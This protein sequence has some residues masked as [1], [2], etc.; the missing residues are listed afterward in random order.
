MLT[1][2]AY[3]MCVE[4]F[5]TPDLGCSV[6]AGDNHKHAY[7]GVPNL[8]AED[9]GVH[10]RHPTTTRTTFHQQGCFTISRNCYS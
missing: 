3:D 8:K 1:I 5:R 2:V 9:P 4:H 7:M 10:I 6:I